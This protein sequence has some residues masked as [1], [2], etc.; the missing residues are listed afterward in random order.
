[1]IIVP[2]WSLCPA[3]RCWRR[4]RPFCNPPCLTAT[5]AISSYVVNYAL[6]IAD[7]RILLF[8]A[9]RPST[10]NAY[11][12][13]TI[14]YRATLELWRKMVFL[15]MI[16]PLTLLNASFFR[17]R[18]SQR[19]KRGRRHHRNWVRVSDFFDRKEFKLE[20]FGK[21]MIVYENQVDSKDFNN[22]LCGFWGLLQTQS[23]EV[24]SWPLRWKRLYSLKS[25][26]FTTLWWKSMRDATRWRW[27]RN[28]FIWGLTTL[29]N[30]WCSGCWR[31]DLLC[32]C[33]IGASLIWV[34]KERGIVWNRGHIEDKSRKS[35]GGPRSHQDGSLCFGK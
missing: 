19:S 7:S 31:Q 26:N 18:P 15:L 29:P 35:Y 21:R 27:T 32:Q 11:D 14:S 13:L 17:D 4:F 12:Q 23:W 24:A 5:Y 8:G 33:P 2:N 9:F 16:M 30:S 25:W 6:A 20:D 1:M 22:Y 34:C 10:S 28:I 3:I